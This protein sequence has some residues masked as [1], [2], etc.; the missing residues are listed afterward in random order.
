MTDNSDN[1]APF[2]DQPGRIND[3]LQGMRESA[4]QK[5]KT[6]AETLG[7]VVGIRAWSA[8]NRY[9]KNRSS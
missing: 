5:A 9:K 7:V 8:Y 1:G 6:A 2:S 4:D 3:F